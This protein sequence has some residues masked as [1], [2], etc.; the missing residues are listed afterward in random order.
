M[1]Y[2]VW[3]L[4]KCSV[5]D[6]IW[7]SSKLFNWNASFFHNIGMRGFNVIKILSYWLHV[8]IIIKVVLTEMLVFPSQ[9][10]SIVQMQELLSKHRE[11][12]ILC[13]GFTTFCFRTI[14]LYFYVCSWNLYVMNFQKPRM[15][16][17]FTSC[18]TPV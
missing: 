10:F 5:I 18:G 15:E 7:I 4:L 8:N 17:P 13:R 2:E 14:I 9:E 6:C 12:S 11:H 3:M 16:L 1:V